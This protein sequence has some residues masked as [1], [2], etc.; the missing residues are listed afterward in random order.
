MDGT[1]LLV[2]APGTSGAGGGS[3]YVFERNGQ[4]WTELGRFQRT[5]GFTAANFGVSVDFEGE[6]VVV[7]SSGS[8]FAFRLVT[9]APPASYCT[10]GTTASGCTAELTASGTPSAS[11]ASGFTLTASDVEGKRDGTIYFGTGGAQANP[12]GNGTSFQCVTP[13]TVRTGVLQGSGT[14]GACDNVLALD[15]NAWWAQHPGQHPGPGTV[16]YAQC[17][18]RDPGNGSNQDTSLS[19]GFSFT[20]C[21]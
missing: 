8:G 10:A 21:P 14:A 15:L 18:F 7:G 2:G 12:W 20:I 16:V 9:P 5:Q 19:E 6:R 11:L 1:R 13:P 4:T 17:W 3:V